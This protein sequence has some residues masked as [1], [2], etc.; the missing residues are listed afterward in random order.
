M[1]RFSNQERGDP[2]Q[3]RG[4][5]APAAAS[6]YSYLSREMGLDDTETKMENDAEMDHD[7]N[8]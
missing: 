7:N 6:L 3:G 2:G 4:P 8:R 5:Q 1:S